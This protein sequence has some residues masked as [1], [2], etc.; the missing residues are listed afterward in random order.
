MKPK[1]STLAVGPSAQ[2]TAARGVPLV[3]TRGPG[4]DSQVRERFTSVIPHLPSCYPVP[5][6]WLR[7]LAHRGQGRLRAG[8]EGE[9]RLL[10]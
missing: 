6:L 2:P 7:H 3:S 9:W 10:F 1:K 4:P 5:P 8:R